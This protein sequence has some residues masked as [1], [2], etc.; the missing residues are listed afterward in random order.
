MK[1]ELIK[2]VITA[3]CISGLFT[4][5]LAAIPQIAT[6]A[7][8]NTTTTITSSAD[9]ASSATTSAELPVSSI[10][11]ENETVTQPA[12]TTDLTFTYTLPQNQPQT[13]DQMVIRLTDFAKDWSNHE[14][15][16][17]VPAGL[18]F[19]LERTKVINDEATNLTFDQAQQ[20]VVV[21]QLN[22]DQLANGLSFV[23]IPDTAQTYQLSFK[24][25]TEQLLQ[26]TTKFTVVQAETESSTSSSTSESEASSSSSE[27]SSSESASSS[28]AFRV[29]NSEKSDE[30]ATAP[31]TA[32]KNVSK[33]VKDA[34]Q[35]VVSNW[36][37]FAAAYTSA[38]VTKITLGHDVMFD[39]TTVTT[40]RHTDNS[41]E[42]DG[43]GNQLNLRNGSVLSAYAVLELNST[44]V[45]NPK[46]YL[47][48]LDLVKSANSADGPGS[49]ILSIYG[50]SNSKNWD[51]EFRNITSGSKGSVGLGSTLIT[52]SGNVTF[53]GNNEIYQ[54]KALL[55]AHNFTLKAGSKLICISSTLNAAPIVS[56]K[57]NGVYGDAIVDKNSILTLRSSNTGFQS[58]NGLLFHFARISV[59]ENAIFNN[60]ICGSAISFP[61]NNQSFEIKSGAIVNSTTYN[62]SSGTP[63]FPVIRFMGTGDSLTV[64][65]GGYLY[66]VGQ[67]VNGVV[68]FYYS[69]WAQQ[70]SLIMNNPGGYDL[71]NTNGTFA[72]NIGGTNNN[73]KINN[74]AISVWKN[75]TNQDKSPDYSASPATLTADS[76]NALTMTGGTPPSKKITD[77]S[78]ISGVIGMPILEFHE[79]TDADKSAFAE[80]ILSRIP[81]PS[82]IGENNE[83]TYITDVAQ[84]G[85]AKVVLANS[86]QTV[87]TS[88]ESEFAWPN[89][90]TSPSF[91]YNTKFTQDTF[92][93]AG[94]L[95]T[96]TASILKNDPVLTTKGSVTVQ[97]V[98]PPT[99]TQVDAVTTQATKLSGSEAE[100]GASVTVTLKRGGVTTL[101]S[102]Q[103]TVD[104]DGKWD[105]SLPGEILP[106]QD[107][108]EL[109]LFLTDTAGNIEPAV[110]EQYHDATFPAATIIEVS[111]G[112]IGLEAPALIDFGI[113]KVNY[114][115][116]TIEEKDPVTI[117]GQLAITDTRS[118]HTDWQLNATLLPK[119]DQDLDLPNNVLGVTKQ[120]VDGQ[121]LL[122]AQRNVV[123][124]GKETSADTHVLV[125]SSTGTTNANDELGFKFVLPEELKL[126]MDSTYA[127]VIQWD[128]SDVPT[129]A[130]DLTAPIN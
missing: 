28:D 7:T 129:E 3:I 96:A 114:G 127:G 64:D 46:V 75:G 18:Q 42:I 63:N 77:Y 103:V 82:G 123:A 10:V 67:S 98:T 36:Q 122:N 59:E 52:T 76:S 57:V 117:T 22:T 97:D 33:Q 45:N 26:T 15:Q 61:D 108:D 14:L 80:T 74:A 54:Q 107:G 91:K 71:R 84:A 34:T 51:F 53:S 31:K 113:L 88:N 48:D 20:L 130:L 32:E 112:S 119:T 30:Q 78:R 106:L 58:D 17:E 109:Q 13:G 35:V 50:L 102:G 72:V 55:T 39:G 44:V 116:D 8:T 94:D 66:A 73:F 9:G 120:S 128:L 68:N 70:G 110:E 41:L 118:T 105:Y 125:H 79:V 24:D 6:S 11:D 21:K 5:E 56:N 93:K 62:R 115:N 99:P 95:L 65:E 124:V 40:I 60:S 12:T 90:V 87:L 37:E 1:K 25:E 2:K 92:F 23:F 100:M 29:E 19:N 111:D 86:N 83:P 4:S 27:S 104:A 126:Q 49:S 101:L 89:P 38:T 85:D 47:H 81:D 16:F 43:A 69:T 121:T